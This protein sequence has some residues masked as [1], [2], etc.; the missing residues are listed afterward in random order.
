MGAN[1]ERVKRVPFLF[2]TLFKSI[3]VPIPGECLASL[4][5][6]PCTSHHTSGKTPQHSNFAHLRAKWQSANE[7]LLRLDLVHPDSL[8]LIDAWFFDWI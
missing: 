4:L 2:C 6:S 8:A 7:V 3:P 1:L 5:L